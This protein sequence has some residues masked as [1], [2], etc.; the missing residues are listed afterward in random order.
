[1]IVELV[2]LLV[3]VDF[4]VEE[5]VVF[6]DEVVLADEVDTALLLDELVFRMLEVVAFAL[7]LEVVLAVVEVVFSVV[8]LLVVFAVAE[9]V[10]AVLEVVFEVDV[11]SLTGVDFL[12]EDVAALTSVDFFVDVLL[13]EDDEELTTFF[14]WGSLL[15]PAKAPGALLDS[16][17]TKSD[18]PLTWRTCSSRWS[19]SS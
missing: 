13:R 3:V 5:E 12:D 4:L 2:F 17:L 16:A 14:I 10:F 1:L 7:A 9:E 15:P 6:W 19:G 18:T 11:A 8:E